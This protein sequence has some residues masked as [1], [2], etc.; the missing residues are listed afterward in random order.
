MIGIAEMAL[1]GLRGPLAGALHEVEKTAHVA[2][3]MPTAVAAV[4]GLDGVM[5]RAEVAA[6]VVPD[7]AVD[8]MGAEET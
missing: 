1:T 3:Q 7:C 2:L 4:V 6:V 8:L 5:T